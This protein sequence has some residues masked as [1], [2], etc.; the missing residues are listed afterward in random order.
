[1]LPK[2]ARAE[3]ADVYSMFRTKARERQEALALDDGETR[4]SYGTF[5][6]RVDRLAAVLLARGVAWEIGWKS[7]RTT[8]PSTLSCNWLAPG[9][10]PSSPA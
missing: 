8:A 1:M 3:Q 10:G 9:S 7:C 5:M 2:V 6:G 4:H